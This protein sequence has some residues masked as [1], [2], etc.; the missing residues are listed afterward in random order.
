MA[1]D[2][3]EN[4]LDSQATTA[5]VAHGKP[6][7]R[8]SR[9]TLVASAPLS[10]QDVQVVENLLAVFVARAYAADHPELFGRAAGENTGEGGGE[11][12]LT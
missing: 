10:D 3:N 2:R 5:K 11:P 9:R 4:P 8:F 1:F 6:L 12:G 7:R